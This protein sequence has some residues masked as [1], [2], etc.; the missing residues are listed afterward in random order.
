MKRFIT[1]NGQEFELKKY[2]NGKIEDVISNM[3]SCSKMLDDCYGRPSERKKA[4]FDY[5]FRWYYENE[6]MFGFGI[7]SYNT[8]IFTLQA[9]MMFTDDIYG[10]VDITPTHN[11]VWVND[12]DEVKSVWN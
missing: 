8:H 10:L 12:I 3:V 6:N 1:I 7:R 4:I 9:Y 2:R 11:Y 5:W